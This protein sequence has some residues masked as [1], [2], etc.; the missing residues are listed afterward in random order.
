[1]FRV[2]P[3]EWPSLQEVV[4]GMTELSVRSGVVQR[5]EWR[6][7]QTGVR[8]GWKDKHVT[9]HAEPKLKERGIA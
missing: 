2:G 8:R 6:Q 3:E 7:G 5:L 9:H 1:M 4:P